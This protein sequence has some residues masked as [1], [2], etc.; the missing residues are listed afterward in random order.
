MDE[1]RASRWK[2]SRIAAGSIIMVAIVAAA[3][4]IGGRQSFE[5]IGTGGVNLSLLPKVGQAAPDFIV[6]TA[7]EG[8]PVRLSDYRG[9]PVWLN[10]WGSWC[11]PCRAEMPELQAA[12]EQLRPKGLEILAIS[13][14]EPAADAAAFAELNG[15]TYMILSDPRREYTGASYPIFNFPTHILVDAEGVIRDIVL[16]PIDEAEIL[17]RAQL[18]LPDPE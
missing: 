10:F 4:Y 9:K 14:N 17:E 11:P 1:H 13:L 18:I 12:Y 8:R 15:A 2:W 6:G 7:A 5:Q 3:W 16:A